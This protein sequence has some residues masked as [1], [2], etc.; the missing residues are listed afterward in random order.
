MTFEREA[1][2]ALRSQQ[3]TGSA[4]RD[5]RVGETLFTR[6]MVGEAVIPRKRLLISSRAIGTLHVRCRRSEL[7][8]HRPLSL[9]ASGSRMGNEVAVRIGSFNANGRALVSNRCVGARYVV[10]S[11]QLRVLSAARTSYEQRRYSLPLGT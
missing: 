3:T 10:N 1:P 5:R 4:Q 6:E 9:R 2:R 8:V 7:R 11:A